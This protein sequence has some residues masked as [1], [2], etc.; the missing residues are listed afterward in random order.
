[1]Q[2]TRV[3]IFKTLDKW[4][5]TKDSISGS[6]KNEMTKIGLFLHRSGMRSSYH[7]SLKTSKRPQ[8][9]KRE[10]SRVLWAATKEW[11]G[12][13]QKQL[14]LKTKTSKTQGFLYKE[15]MGEKGEG[16]LWNRMGRGAEIGGGV[17]FGK[18]LRNRVQ[19]VHSTKTRETAHRPTALS[20]LTIHK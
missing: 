12:E 15:R 18:R 17:V 7:Y 14:K 9:R 2:Q 4:S 20:D 13:P 19:C 5:R 8:G 16:K 10:G 1:M 3:Y 6:G 11:E